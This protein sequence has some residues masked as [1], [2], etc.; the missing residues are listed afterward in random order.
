MKKI[1]FK[2]YINGEPAKVTGIDVDGSMGFHLMLRND[3]ENEEQDIKVDAGAYLK[4]ENLSY[5]WI[6]QY[7]KKDDE[8]II[9][10][11]SDEEFDDP[12]EVKPYDNP[13][14]N[15]FILKSKL[16]SYYKLKEELKDHLKE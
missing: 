12:I 7:L 16:K 1:G 14:L 13:E 2:I 6:S 10:V 15:D 5:K 8:I 4:N 11:V 3:L 9:K